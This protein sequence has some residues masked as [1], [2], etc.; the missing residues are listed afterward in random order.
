MPR[1]KARSP[2]LGLDV[3]AAPGWHWFNSCKG[4]GDRFLPT[5]MIGS[6]QVVASSWV[7][8]STQKGVTSLALDAHS[9]GLVDLPPAL[10]TQLDQAGSVSNENLSCVVWI[11]HPKRTSTGDFHGGRVLRH[12]QI[13]V[14]T[15]MRS[16]REVAGGCSV[17]IM[18]AHLRSYIEAKDVLGI[19][20]LGSSPEGTDFDLNFGV[21]VG[22]RATGANGA[23]LFGRVATSII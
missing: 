8:S 23:I 3:A 21:P 6:P 22:A 18:S 9:P 14:Q 5:P 2:T 19:L 15:P 1:N 12:F 13:V 4:K 7:P 10:P 17:S 11:L 16:F 20:I